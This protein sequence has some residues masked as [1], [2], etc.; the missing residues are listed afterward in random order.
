MDPIVTKHCPC[1]EQALVD[2]PDLVFSDTWRTIIRNGI[3][4]K[5]TPLQYKILQAVRH[6]R[7]TVPRL[8]ELLYQD[9]ADGGPE[10]AN[11]VIHVTMSAMNKRLKAINMKIGGERPG[12]F[13]TIRLK[14]LEEDP[15]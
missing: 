13:A 15:T 7:V 4:V 9:R 3:C 8:V 11:N 10:C 2:K 12:P 6:H 14:T 1:C 5:L